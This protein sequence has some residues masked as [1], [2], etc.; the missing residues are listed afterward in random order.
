MLTISAVILSLLLIPTAFCFLYLKVLFPKNT[1]RLHEAHLIPFG[2]ALTLLANLQSLPEIVNL[3]LAPCCS[4]QDAFYSV[5]S[6][7]LTKVYSGLLWQYLC[8]VLRPFMIFTVPMTICYWV[9]RLGIT[10]FNCWIPKATANLGKRILLGIP[11]FIFNLFQNLFVNYLGT[12]TAFNPKKSALFVDILGDDNTLYSGIFLNYFMEN[13]VLVGIQL[14]NVIRF[15]PKSEKSRSESE[16]AKLKLS[17]MSLESPYPDLDLLL[18][19]AYPT[20]Y[21][22]PNNGTMFFPIEKIKNY[23]FWSMKWGQSEEIYL[24][25]PDY[26]TKFAWLL[27]VRYSLPH[28]ELSIRG[29]LMPGE[30]QIFNGDELERSLNTLGLDESDL[31]QR[32]FIKKSST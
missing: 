4:T 5:Y 11:R 10:H 3:A 22:L 28:L 12:L 19:A 15:H 29:F 16:A 1:L 14:S 13:R 7:H 30:Q 24:L 2:I 6:D 18:K 21:L 26:Q 9:W 32:L 27:G 17:S 23:H 31:D 20:P 25:R 8:F